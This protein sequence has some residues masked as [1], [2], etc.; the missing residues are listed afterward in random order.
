MGEL[1]FLKVVSK[2]AVKNNR[3]NAAKELA[4]I[5]NAEDFIIFIHD[6]KIDSFLPAPGFQQTLQNI[7]GWHAFLKMCKFELCRGV[8]PY[9][10]GNGCS[11]AIG[12]VIDNS[13]V[14][15]IGGNPLEHDFNK[16]EAIS[17]LIVALLNSELESISTK[18]VA[19][20][21][22]K[23]IEKAERIA[24]A[25][26]G[27]RRKLNSSYVELSKKNQALIKT[28]NDL[29]NFIYTASHDLK[30]PISNIEGL[31]IAF[32]DDE[33]FDEGKNALLDMMFHSI[34]RFKTTIKDLT[35]ITK[36]HRPEDLDLQDL[37]FYEILDEVKLD[38]RGLIET[39]NPDIELAFTVP[40]I[41]YPRKN[42]RSIIYNLLS[43]SLKYSSPDRIP[44][45]RIATEKKGNYIILKISD[46][47]LG[48]SAENQ[49]KIFGMFK[50]AHQHIDGTGIGLYMIKRMI[51]NT[52][53]K[54]EVES[55]VGIGT[56]FCVYFLIQ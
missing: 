13:I 24:I 49:T 41:N 39:L 29:D 16:L 46:N 26:D 32:K 50:R 31:L 3:K 1:N 36:V 51:E 12:I 28:N 42:L 45:I 52:G 6:Q 10:D 48:L 44:K 18:S 47:G 22:S 53:G 23:E 38:I 11:P 2:F 25:L 43:N 9:P 15:L 7:G 33:V 8:V 17:P 27:M 37:Y 56:T 55:Q 14:I 4:E 35:E 5:L 21:A 40:N 20:T 34:E 54:I 19:I 30:A